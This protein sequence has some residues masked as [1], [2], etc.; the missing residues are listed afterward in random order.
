MEYSLLSATTRLGRRAALVLILLGALSIAMP[1]L[2]GLALEW[3]VALGLTL[4][5]IS[6]IGVA[7]HLR[8]AAGFPLRVMLALLTLLAGLYLWIHPGAGLALATLLLGLYFFIDGLANVIG[9][10][11]GQRPPLG[12]LN[13]VVTLGLA[14]VILWLW[15][16]SGRYVIGVLIGI[17]LVL[18]GLILWLASDRVKQTAQQ[19]AEAEEEARFARAREVQERDDP[20]RRD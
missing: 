2:T 3:L 15:P 16:D 4:V 20:E 9:S 11:Y 5:G 1:W 8:H 18:M 14:L 12:L 7:W 6:Q 13:G 19:V 17:K 10:R